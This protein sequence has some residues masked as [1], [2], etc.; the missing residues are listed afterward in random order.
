MVM[1]SEEQL[2]FG[3]DP[4][5]IARDELRQIVGAGQE[6]TWETAQ[7]IADMAGVAIRTVWYWA[8]TERAHT[9]EQA[10]GE[11]RRDSFSVSPL[12]AQ[13]G[14]SSIL[15]RGRWCTR[16]AATCG[17]FTANCQGIS[18]CRPTRR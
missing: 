11:D 3:F 14:L 4:K 18:P 15:L 5:A 13:E 6:L 9:E 7:A 8:A 16:W 10:A 1:S 17:S 2:G 12:T